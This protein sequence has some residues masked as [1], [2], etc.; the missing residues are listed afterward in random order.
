MR[1]LHCCL[2][3]F[4]I[5]NHNYQENALPRQNKVDGHEVLILASTETIMSNNKLGYVNPSKYVNEDGIN[6]IRIPYRSYLPHT[7]MKKIRAYKDAFRYISDF[8]PD[9][10]LFHGSGAYEIAKVAKYKKSHPEVKLFVDSHTDFN[11]SARGFL[12]KDILHRMLYKRFINKALPC[13][14]KVLC[15]SIEC[16]DFLREFYE[17]PNQKL[18]IYPLGGTVFE[19]DEYSI[20]RKRIR[21]ELQL[22]DTNILFVHSGKMDR[23]KRTSKLLKAFKEVPSDR[24]KLILIGRI[25]KDMEAE[26]LSFVD[27]DSRVDF[28][29]W[30]SIEELQEYL[31]AADM[32]LQPGSQSAT[33]QNAICCGCP[34]MLYPHK[35][36]KPYLKG[37]GF[38][39]ETVKDM[40]DVFKTI[41]SNPEILKDMSEASYKVAYDLLD[42]R[43][44]AARL[45]E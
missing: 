28:L 22:D 17:I 26:I 7:I 5:D 38:F 8:R 37:N 14:D 9:V 39:V 1:I 16:Y 19:E 43:K 29:G 35:S 24:L 42:Y 23:A 11:K 12:S 31:C 34:V 10:I 33:M 18:E 41:D 30:K 6:V 40:T 44:L 20:K 2:S 15:V 4:Y 25:P 13:I 27:N 45:Y 32:Y 3:S 21:A 36:H